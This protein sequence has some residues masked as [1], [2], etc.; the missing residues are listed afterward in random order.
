MPAG[1]GT[2]AKP[3]CAALFIRRGRLGSGTLGEA[4]DGF[5]FGLVHIED[6]QQLGD[7]QDFLELAAQM[8]EPQRGALRLH[9]VMRGDQRA[10]AGAVNEGYVVHIQDNFLFSF[11]EQAFYFLA[12][13][14]AFLAEHNA[15][16]Q[17]DHSHAVHF[18][19]RH[20]QSHVSS[21]SSENG[22]GGNPRRSRK[23]YQKRMFPGALHRKSKTGQRSNHQAPN[24]SPRRT[25]NSR[26]PNRS[27]YSAE[28]P[29][30]ASKRDSTAKDLRQDRRGSDCSARLQPM[31]RQAVPTR[32][33]PA[34][35]PTSRRVPRLDGY[36][37]VKGIGDR[38]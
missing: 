15:A 1:K 24:N 25:C 5:G 38:E 27:T 31:E 21:S 16:V 32:P 11:G 19:V 10:E 20:L 37:T 36:N 9:G 4:G 34:L 8:A 6:G 28:T 18:A 13:G 22:S 29:T 23:V 7:L 35:T 33:G 2:R 12:Q 14:I 26:I 30:A 3:A 17:R